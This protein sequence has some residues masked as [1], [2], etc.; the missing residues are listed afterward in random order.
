MVFSFFSLILSLLAFDW[1][2]DGCNPLV[3][4]CRKNRAVFGSQEGLSCG[5]LWAK[6]VFSSS[7]CDFF[8]NRALSE[9]SFS[10]VTLN[11]SFPSLKPLRF[12]HCLPAQRSNSLAY[13]LWH[14]RGRPRCISCYSFLL[15]SS[16]NHLRSRLIAWCSF[17]HLGSGKSSL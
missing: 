14:W 4:H 6:G 11:F 12:C 15:P 3:S 5:S 2:L 1:V 13:P 9:R 17:F 10:N 8:H 7:S 16:P